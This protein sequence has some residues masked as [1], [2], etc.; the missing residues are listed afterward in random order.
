[1]IEKDDIFLSKW[2]N[3]QLTDKELNDFKASEDYPLYLK[4]IE[5]TDKLQA[6]SYDINT[7][8]ELLKKKRNSINTKQSNQWRFINIAASIT[9]LIG[10]FTYF[11]FFKTTTYSTSFGEQLSFKLPDGSVVT[12]NSKSSISFN[13]YNWS[14]HRTLSLKGEAY[15]DVEKGNT[16]TVTSHLGDVSVLG[17]EFNI[18][19]TNQYFNVTCYEGKVKVTDKKNSSEHLLTPNIGYQHIS[20]LNAQEL[21]F[22]NTQPKWLEQQSVFES[23][24][25]KLVFKSL[26]KH[27]NI[28]FDYTNF[29]DSV[30]FTGA[31]PNNNQHI[32]LETVLKSVNLTYT[33]KENRV[34]L[35]D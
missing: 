24:P 5:G 8:F 21:T 33:I 35:D 13:T 7:A 20:G 16:F 25:I 4:I 23:T 19:T 28:T 2:L 10:L 17:T 27:Y 30:L 26:E 32:A 18:N 11:N 12:L 14:E 15:F 6:P 1:M 31:F 9:L 3:N 22:K 34:I 29:D